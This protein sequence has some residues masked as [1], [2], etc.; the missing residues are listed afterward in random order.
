MLN[1]KIKI[2]DRIDDLD[3]LDEDLNN[4]IR[5]GQCLIENNITI[6]ACESMTGGLFASKLVENVGI[7]KVFDRAIITY[8]D[9]AKM[10]ELCVNRQT[11]EEY[12]AESSQVALEMV[13]GLKAKTKSRLNISVTGLA[14]NVLDKKGLVKREGGIF[15]IGIIYEYDDNKIEKVVMFDSKSNDRD[16]NR[17]FAVTEMFNEIENVLRESKIILK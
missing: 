17:N 14:N 16:F 5:V 8:T 10:D 13:Q 15:Y 9:K 1:E 11:L 6:S 2:L 3:E 4:H 12:T 7:S